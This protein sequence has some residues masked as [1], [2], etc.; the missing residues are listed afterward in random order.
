RV[1]IAREDPRGVGVRLAAPQLAVGGTED[2]RLAAQ[3]PHRELERDARPG[4][5]LLENE[6]QRSPL[7]RTVAPP[8]LVGKAEI[9]DVVQFGGVVLVDVE[10]VAR[11]LVEPPATQQ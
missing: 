4:R 10:E 3:L 2:D 8:R 7:K 9:E 6:R 1:D 5:R 11:R